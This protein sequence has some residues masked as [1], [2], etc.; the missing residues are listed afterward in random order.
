VGEGAKATVLVVDDDQTSLKIIT[1]LLDAAGLRVITAKDGKEALASL[2]EPLPDLIVSDWMMPEMS[3]LELC[4]QVKSNNKTSGIYFII[5]TAKSETKNIVEG[6]N[7]G[8]DEYLVKPFDH[9]ELVARVRTGLRIRSLQKEL[10]ESERLAAAAQ[11]A[12]TFAHK[13]NNLLQSIV[14]F[15][16]L[17]LNNPSDNETTISALRQIEKAAQHMSTLIRQL[18]QIRSTPTKSYLGR[19]EM[20][21]LDSAINHRRR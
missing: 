18:Q 12:V 7:E 4:R 20:I 8:A 3:G 16:Q 14:G 19:T 11:M 21:D 2:A 13:L 6:L 1:K 15:A 10:V 5:L 9:K 17:A